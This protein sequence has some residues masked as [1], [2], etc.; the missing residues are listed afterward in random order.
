MSLLE[1]ETHGPI[2]RKIGNELNSKSVIC[3][4]TGKVYKSILEASKDTGIAR[5]TIHRHLVGKQ[6]DGFKYKYHWRYN[7]NK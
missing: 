6:A 5:A 3:V 7:D 1:Y 4:E 2:R